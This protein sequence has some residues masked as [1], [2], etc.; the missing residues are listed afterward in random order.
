MLLYSLFN[1]WALDCHRHRRR[2]YHQRQPH[3]FH[4]SFPAAVVAVVEACA[5]QTIT[6]HTKHGQ[7]VL[8]TSCRIKNCTIKPRQYRGPSPHNLYS[9]IACLMSAA[10]RLISTSTGSTS[11]LPLRGCYLTPSQT[12]PHTHKHHGSSSVFRGV[13]FMLRFGWL[14]HNH[15]WNARWTTIENFPG[16]ILFRGWGEGHCTPCVLYYHCFSY[17]DSMGNFTRIYMV[18]RSIICTVAPGSVEW[19][20]GLSI[21]PPWAVSCVQF[22]MPLFN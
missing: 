12:P 22:W 8:H 3:P 19:T 11:W 5:L 4:G 17:D 6:L 9:S 14:N 15:A 10:M 7:W 13:C 21:W 20:H 2:R 16:N 1:T 18:V